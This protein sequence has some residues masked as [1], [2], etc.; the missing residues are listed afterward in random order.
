MRKMFAILSTTLC[1]FL[2]I[3]CVGNPARQVDISVYDF[4]NL[5]GAWAS[6]GFPV[7]AVEVRAT[8]WLDS[9]AQLYRLGYVDP[10]QRRR[11]AASRWIAPPAELLERFLQRR[12]VFGQ[13][14]FAGPGCRLALTLDELEQRFDTEQSSQTVVEVR[15]RLLPPHGETLLSKRAF[16]IR[17]PAP[18]PDARGGVAATREAVQLLARELASWLDEVA[19]QRPQTVAMCKEKVEEATQPAR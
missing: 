8:S 13:P 19:R 9:P 6:P 17:K 16:L 12:I 14:D 15:A 3:G 11:Y 1:A 10:L 18:T 2:L 5:A 7:A 4:G